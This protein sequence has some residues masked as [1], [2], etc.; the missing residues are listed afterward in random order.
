MCHSEKIFPEMKKD[1]DGKQNGG[2]PL[3]M[4]NTN[5]QAPKGGELH[6]MSDKF[7]IGGQFMPEPDVFASSKR[8]VKKAVAKFIEFQD[9]SIL[10]EMYGKFWVA[11]KVNGNRRMIAW[12]TTDEEAK[13][14]VGY[15]RSMIE[16]RLG[17]SPIDWEDKA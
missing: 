2:Y 17:G 4:S 11:V 6:K 7:Y 16:V 9:P 15:L 10:P 5:L 12:A 8:K 3:R 14:L 13:E 1:V